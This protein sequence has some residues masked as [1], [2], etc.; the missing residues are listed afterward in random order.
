VNIWEQLQPRRSTQVATFMYIVV[1]I[2]RH[3]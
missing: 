2:I 1:A 3:F